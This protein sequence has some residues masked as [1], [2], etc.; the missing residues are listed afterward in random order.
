MIGGK[1]LF[2]A[3]AS[4]KVPIPVYAEMGSVN[5]VFILPD[6]LQ[7]KAKEI[8][9]GLSQSATLSV[10]QFCTNP[11]IIGFRGYCEYQ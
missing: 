10:G 5:P 7:S 11:G 8:A 9:D 2:D 6:A 3:A 1:S 4:R